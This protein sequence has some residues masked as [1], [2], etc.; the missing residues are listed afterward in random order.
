MYLS[1]DLLVFH[2]KLKNFAIYTVISGYGWEGC[3]VIYELVIS[4]KAGRKVNVGNAWFRVL[5]LSLC[6]CLSVCLSLSQ[7]EFCVCW[8]H[9]P[10][11]DLR[12]LS[13]NLSFITFFSSDRI[14]LGFL[15]FLP[16]RSQIGRKITFNYFYFLTN[17]IDISLCADPM[18]RNPFSPLWRKSALITPGECSRGR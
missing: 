5:C 13:R 15:S 4:F 3:S 6:L 8:C 11:F 10:S 9:L 1:A 18:R 16:R 17:F 7:L 2:F 12:L 14:R